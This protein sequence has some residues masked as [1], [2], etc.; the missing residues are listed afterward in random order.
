MLRSGRERT[1]HQQFL[2]QAEPCLGGNPIDRHQLGQAYAMLPRQT[3]QCVAR[4][5]RVNLVDLVV[6]RRRRRSCPFV[7]QKALAVP[8]IVGIRQVVEF[9][10]ALN[11]CS[12]LSGDL[13]QRFTRLDDVLFIGVDGAGK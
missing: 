10:Q 6:L 12:I 2:T 11:R 8:D 1:G 9:L 5:D 7:N 13:A 4:L 3:E